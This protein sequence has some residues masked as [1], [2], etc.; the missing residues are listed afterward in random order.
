MKIY[1]SGI[2]M[3]VRRKKIKNLYL[4]IKPP[5]GRVEI[6]APLSM[7]DKM[8]E[9]FV[10]GKL[11]W[12]RRQ[13]KKYEHARKK[14]GNMNPGKYYMYGGSRTDWFIRRAGGRTPLSC[15]GMKGYYPCGVAVP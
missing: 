1:I 6:S 5:D 2:G 7:P 8:I 3:E 12:I 9:D 4:S 14:N 15:A 11:E 10:R 13:R